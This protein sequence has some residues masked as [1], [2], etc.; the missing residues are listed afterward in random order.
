MSKR[1]QV[2][3][4]GIAHRIATGATRGLALKPLSVAAAGDS[5]LSELDSM[6]RA[7]RQQAEASHVLVSRTK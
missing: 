3:H 2:D 5:K 6:A 4:A 7:W 1:H